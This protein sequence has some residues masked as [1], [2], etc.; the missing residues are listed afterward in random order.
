MTTQSPSLLPQPSRG[1]TAAGYFRCGCGG[2][3][4]MIVVLDDGAHVPVCWIGLQV[5]DKVGDRRIVAI[6]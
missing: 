2:A 6:L 4:R 3:V 1:A 5:G